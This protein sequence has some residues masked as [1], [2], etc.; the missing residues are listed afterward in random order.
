MAFWIPRSNCGVSRPSGVIRYSPGRRA[1]ATIGRLASGNSY[2]GSSLGSTQASGWPSAPWGSPVKTVDVPDIQQNL[3]VRI[4]MG[5]LD[6]WPRGGHLDAQLFAQ[7][8]RQGDF[9]GF[10]VL[11]LAAGKLPEAALVLGFAT[12]GDENTAIHATNDGGG[13]MNPFQL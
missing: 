10:A 2:C 3:L 12:S 8:A 4:V 5:N 6:Q 9:D 13:D 1:A 7:F 11:D